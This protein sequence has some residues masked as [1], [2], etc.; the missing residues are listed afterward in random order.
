MKR[1]LSTWPCHEKGEH[2]KF[3]ECPEEPETDSECLR[4]ILQELRILNH[5]TRSAGAATERLLRETEMQNR[6]GANR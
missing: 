5:G 4:L 1:P 6:Y 2:D 3:C